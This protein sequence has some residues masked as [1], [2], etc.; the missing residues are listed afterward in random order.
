MLN[1]GYAITTTARDTTITVR[2]RA[3]TAVYRRDGV[4]SREESHA[5]GLARFVKAH[6]L[7]S[8]ADFVKAE[9]PDGST[10]WISRRWVAEG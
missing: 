7:G 2:Y 3:L 8:S 1:S 5:S 10:V 6:R 9:L 4:E